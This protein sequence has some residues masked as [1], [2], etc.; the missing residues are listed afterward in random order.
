MLE[1]T[2]VQRVQRAKDGN[3]FCRLKYLETLKW[4]HPES[5]ILVSGAL[6]LALHMSLKEALQVGD[7][8]S[9]AGTVTLEEAGN[10]GHRMYDCACFPC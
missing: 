1:A 3:G 8:V 10:V 6:R 5:T 9:D 7:D 2:L 4:S